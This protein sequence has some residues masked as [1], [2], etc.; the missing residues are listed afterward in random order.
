M[1]TGY[2]ADIADGKAVTFE[3]FAWGC[4]RAFG[5]LITM[6]DD[7][8]DAEIPGRFEPSSYHAD[9]YEKAL[10]KLAEVKAWSM[11]KA[12]QEADATYHRAHTAW[13]ESQERQKAMRA[14][15]EA[16]LDQA[17]AWEPPSPEHQGFKDFMVEQLTE[18]M[19]FD[20]PEEGRSWWSEPTPLGAADYRDEQIAKAQRDIEYHAEQHA[21]EVERTTERTLWVRALRRALGDPPPKQSDERGTPGA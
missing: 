12:R 15:Y 9:E 17:M 14:R 3:E 13:V 20:C 2:T 16:I 10:V 18:S 11:E 5:A 7:P 21:A 19:R 4:A 8:R 1:P 6:R